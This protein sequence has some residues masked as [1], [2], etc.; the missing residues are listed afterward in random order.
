MD[1]SGQVLAVIG[2]NVNVT[3]GPHPGPRTVYDVQFSDGHT[4]ATWDAALATKAMQIKE[5]GLDADLRGEVVQNGEYTNYK[6]KDIAPSGG[7]PP[8]GLTGVTS[9]PL[10][11]SG[12][13][14]NGGAPPIPIV[15][16]QGGMSPERES[17]IVKQSCLSTAFNFVATLYQGS[18]DTRLNDAIK[19]GL[20]LAKTLYAEVYGQQNVAQTSEEV[21]AI[22]NHHA[23][24][25]V[26]KVGAET[27]EW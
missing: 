19:D 14:T 5:G 9:A 13:P 3:K 15:A 1:S 27:P 2:R 16:S 17:K 24:S 20:E 25:E 11:T 6:L 12:L 22:V 18:E 23:G 7:L 10:T 21:A 4:W 26:V 8:D